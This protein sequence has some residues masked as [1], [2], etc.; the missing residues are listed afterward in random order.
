MVRRMLLALLLCAALLLTACGLPGAPDAFSGT[1]GASAAPDLRLLEW[2]AMSDAVPDETEAPASG[3]PLLVDLWLDASQVMGGINIHEES[4]YP[5]FSRKY[6]EGGFHYRYGSQ[7]GMYEGVLRCLL[8]AA[9][10]SRV[11]VLRA[12]NERLP[13]ETLDALA[14]SGAEARASVTRDLLTCAVNPLPSFFAGLS[15]EDM[16]GSFYD[17]GTPM[18]NRLRALDASSLE[19]PSLAPAMAGA[20]DAQIAAIQSGETDG[21]VADGDADAPLM[22]A[23]ENLDLTRLSVVTCDPATL[24]RLSAVEADGTPVDFVTELLRARGVFDAGLCVQLYAFVLDYM[25]QMSSFGAA[26]FAEPLL[27]GRLDYDNAAQSSD[28]ALPM[29]RTLIMLVV[30]TPAQVDRYTAL[31]DEGLATS[32]ALKGLRGPTEGQ[33]TYTADGRT[34][35]QQPFGFESFSVRIE[36]PGWT[37][38]TRLSE[39]AALSVSGC[40]FETD[41]QAATVTLDGDA[42]GASVTVSLPVTQESGAASADLSGLTASVSVEAALILTDT[43]PTTAQ[44]GERQVIALRDT[45]YVFTREDEAFRSGGRQSPFTLSAVTPEDGGTR[46]SITVSADEA[47]LVPGYY[48]VLVSADLSGAQVEWEDVPWAASLGVRLTNEQISAWEQFAQAVH[49]YDGGSAGVPRQLQHAWGPVNESGYHGLTIPDFPPVMRAPGLE[50]LIAQLRAAAN[51][52]ETPLV[53]YEF[54][55]FVPAGAWEGGV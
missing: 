20:L 12:G 45:Q 21:Y 46:L 32:E 2:P 25:G 44:A 52:D 10:G 24:R 22:Y 50:E 53:R 38:L 6:R 1:D 42:S 51:V 19:N 4:V 36:R 27:W 40:T 28:Q 41:G 18:L 9:E 48:R 13:D 31:L 7:V 37:C 14:G 5:H 55:V 26:D 23:L 39:G 43:L 17:L 49:T 8:A 3:A 29:P 54:D 35:T 16:E 33:L 34:V 11:R 47:A 15:A 30:G